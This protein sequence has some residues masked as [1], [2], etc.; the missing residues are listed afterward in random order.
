M[1]IL[2]LSARDATDEKIAALDLGADDYITKPFDG[3]EL[4]ARLRSAL[5]RAGVQGA[6]DGVLRHGPITIDRAR[7][8]MMLNNE[9]VPLTRREFSVLVMFVEAGG[10]I[11]THQADPAR[12]VG[13]GP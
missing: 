6:Q 5:R 9:P 11:L 12:R 4:L 10:R 7:H 3:D 13:S 8:R 2:I 1:P